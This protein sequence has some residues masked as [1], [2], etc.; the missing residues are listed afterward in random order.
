MSSSSTFFLTSSLPS[1]QIWLL[2]VP[3][4]SH[5]MMAV[6]LLRNRTCT[7][8]LLPET[9]ARSLTDPPSVTL[10]IPARNEAANIRDCVAS[11]LL[12]RYPRLEVR[13][14]DDHSTD[15]TGDLARAIGDPRL[16]VISAPDLPPGW[17]GNMP[18]NSNAGV[19]AQNQYIGC[20]ALLLPFIEQDNLYKQCKTSAPLV[21]NEDVTFSQQSTP[22]TPI[23]FRTRPRRMMLSSGPAFAF[24]PRFCA[25]P[26]LLM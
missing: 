16:K 5:L 25:K 7:P 14:I 17:L 15:G 24:T 2:G 12:Q 6:L 18:L 1:W 9:A 23:I 26:C 8:P 10:L 22:T 21:W 4:F 3:L 13:V 11:A 20:L 19:N